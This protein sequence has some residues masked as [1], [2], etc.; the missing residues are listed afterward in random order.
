MR[1]SAEVS[2]LLVKVALTSR[3]IEVVGVGETFQ[4]GI[5]ISGELQ[6]FD[7]VCAVDFTTVGLRNPIELNRANCGIGV[8][9]K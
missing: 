2:F 6:R 1:P 7:R 3:K 4:Q 9:P 8:R 5:N